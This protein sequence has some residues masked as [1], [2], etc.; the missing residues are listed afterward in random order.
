ML[1]R[2]WA[3]GP[4]YSLVLVSK[5][6]TQQQTWLQRPLNPWLSL[7]SFLMRPVWDMRPCWIT[8]AM[9]ARENEV[10]A[11]SSDWASRPSG[12]KGDKSSSQ[13]RLLESSNLQAHRGSEVSGA[14][15]HRQAKQEHTAHQRHCR[16]SRSRAAVTL[17]D[18]RSPPQPTAQVSD[19][20]HGVLNWIWLYSPQAQTQWKKV[21]W[22]W[23]RDFTRSLTKQKKRRLFPCFTV[24]SHRDKDKRQGRE[25]HPGGK[26]PPP[27]RAFWGKAPKSPGNPETTCTDELF[28]QIN[29]WS[30]MLDLD[31]YK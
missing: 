29:C 24:L 17:R 28:F 8:G 4:I 20:R 25:S 19:Y 6:L 5:A 2:P 9:T 23:K 16:P 14:G 12:Q 22:R 21:V 3:L 13:R 15:P 30:N 10:G 31:F 1:K 27:K 18:P 11:S 7:R 26:P